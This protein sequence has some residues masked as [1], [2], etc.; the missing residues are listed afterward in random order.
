MIRWL[1]RLV[2]LGAL[3]YILT[4]GWVVYATYQAVETLGDGR[5]LP[6]SDGTALVLGSG[7]RGD[8]VLAYSSRRRV[9]LGVR[10]LTEGKAGHLIMSGNTAKYYPATAADVM[11][12]YAIELGAAPEAVSPEPRAWTTF[13]N[14][15]YAKELAEAEGREITVIL[16]DASHVPRAQALAWALGLPDARF[17]AVATPRSALAESGTIPLLREAVAWWLNVGRMIAWRLNGR[18]WPL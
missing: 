16:S 4:L 3:T 14:I 13:E 2:L 1:K 11:T 9:A 17:A 6:A 7:I 15:L 12:A 8:G 18:E 10:L 5:H